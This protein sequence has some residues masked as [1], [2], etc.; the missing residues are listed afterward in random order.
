MNIVLRKEYQR[1]E[2]HSAG[3]VYYESI[4]NAKIKPQAKDMT[5][6]TVKNTI[7]FFMVMLVFS[8][9]YCWYSASSSLDKAVLSTL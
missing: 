9:L 7:H 1:S 6:S 8:C 3:T 2:I 4:D 5:V